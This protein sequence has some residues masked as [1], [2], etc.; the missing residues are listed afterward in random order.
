MA[1]FPISIPAFADL[2]GAQTL[3]TNNHAARHNKVHQEV[4][5]LATKVGVDSSAD[6][7][8]LD[9][10]VAQATK[11]TDTSLAGNSYFL[12]ED[13]MTSNSATKVASQQSIKAY[14]DAAIA[15]NN[16]ALYPVGKIVGSSSVLSAN[17]STYIPGLSGTTWAPYGEGRVMV[18]K[19]GTGTFS[20]GGATGGAETHTL[21]SSEVP[22][23]EVLDAAGQKMR[24]TSGTYGFTSG[25]VGQEYYSSASGDSSY[26]NGGGGSHNNLQPYIV[27][28]LW[29][30]VS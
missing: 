17:P 18:G 25:S 9:Y 20:T 30:R 28:Y 1:D 5:A 16:L 14:V 26:V 21:T 22:A 19:A 7:N 12:D 2:D 4:E 15:A 13:T 10:K 6:T 8:S 23:T 27:T 29:E 3:A 24:R 11:N